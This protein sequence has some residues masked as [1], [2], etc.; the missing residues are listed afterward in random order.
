[1]IIEWMPEPE[2]VLEA[3]SQET[4]EVSIIKA[5]IS[6]MAQGLVVYNANSELVFHNAAY[7]AIYKLRKEDLYH[8][9]PIGKVIERQALSLGLDAEG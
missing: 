2:V 1:M 7:R 8:S 6:H 9:M 5:A 3:D 4:D